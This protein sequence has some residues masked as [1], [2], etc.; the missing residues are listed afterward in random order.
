M[1]NFFEPTEL[2]VALVECYEHI[3]VPLYKPYLRAQMESDMKLV[4]EGKKEKATVLKDCLKEME[5]IFREV[6][7]RRDKMM[8]F[9][10]SVLQNAPPRGGGEKE[11]SKGRG[12]GVDQENRPGPNSASGRQWHRKQGSDSGSSSSGNKF[13]GKRKGGKSTFEPK[14]KRKQKMCSV[15]GVVGRHP[16]GVNCPGMKRRGGKKEAPPASA[17]Q[18]HGDEAGE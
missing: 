2:G 14:S 9:F 3:K 18:T 1:N 6:L 5:R 8:E 10:R 4:A 11:E 15:C 13:A 12:D 16:K 17:S 7:A